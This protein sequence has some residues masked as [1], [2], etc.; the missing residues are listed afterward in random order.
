MGISETRIQCVCTTLLTLIP[1]LITAQRTNS[2]IH[3]TVASVQQ[4]Y[5]LS[6]EAN[7]DETVTK[8]EAL[9]TSM[10][11]FALAVIVDAMQQDSTPSLHDVSIEVI[12]YERHHT[13]TDDS[14]EIDYT[15]TAPQKVLDLAETKTE[16]SIGHP[17]VLQVGGS[18]ELWGVLL[19]FAAERRPSTSSEE[20]VPSMYEQ[21]T[22]TL[23][24]QSDDGLFSRLGWTLTMILLLVAV[25]GCCIL[26][27][28]VAVMIHNGC[29]RGQGEFHH[30][31]SFVVG[32]QNFYRSKTGS[33]TKDERN[34]Q[35][36]I[37]MI[38][39][40]DM[41]GNDTTP[42][43]ATTHTLDHEG[44]PLPTTATRHTQT[45]TGSTA[46]SLES[47]SDAAS[48]SKEDPL[49][50]HSNPPSGRSQDSFSMQTP[51]PNDAALSAM[52]TMTA[53]TPMLSVQSV[54]THDL[55]EEYQYEG[56]TE[57]G[58]DS[59]ITDDDTVR[60]HGHCGSSGTMTPQYADHKPTRRQEDM[61]RTM[62]TNTA[63]AEADDHVDD[64]QED[65][66]P[67]VV[68]EGHYPLTNELESDSYT[69]SSSESTPGTWLW[70][71][72]DSVGISVQIR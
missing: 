62:T 68:Y 19:D 12:H 57:E 30:K 48:V 45:T 27:V 67:D 21:H 18:W 44:P 28:V 29:L 32:F 39:L 50:A 10:N 55:H 43:P 38:E 24:V 41:T 25:I 61:A 42:T 8:L 33:L 35:D 59:A 5:T 46:D 60:G 20:P 63:D 13:M 9:G 7:Y 47:N 64:E 16:Q 2:A 72:E 66:A 65:N 36:N 22:R 53:M 1:I 52:H 37:E 40:Q 23:V 69:D 49:Y 51:I 26:C 11:E 34:L 54:A 17:L 56:S 70:F 3:S 15:M 71:G 58:T 6:V 31:Y 14:I 4:H